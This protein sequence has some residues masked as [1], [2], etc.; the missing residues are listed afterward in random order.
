MPHPTQRVY[1]RDMAVLRKGLEAAG[2]NPTT[3]LDEAFFIGRN[4]I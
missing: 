4:S 2:L 3:D 1:Q